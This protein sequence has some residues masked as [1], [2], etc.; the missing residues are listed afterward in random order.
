MSK[1]ISTRL[2]VNLSL[3][4][5]GVVYRNN[6]VRIK[7]I[8]CLAIN[9][10]PVLSRGSLLVEQYGG[11]DDSANCPNYVQKAH[12][13]NYLTLLVR[14]SNVVPQTLLPRSNKLVVKVRSKM[15]VIDT[16]LR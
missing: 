7:P 5:V 12:C 1:S 6:C 16:P 15:P 3:N 8:C 9:R 13:Y 11:N 10:Q 2:P 4:P 14:P